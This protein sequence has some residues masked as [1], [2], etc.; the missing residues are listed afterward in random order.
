[1]TRQSLVPIAILATSI[2]ALAAPQSATTASKQSENYP[3][4]LARQ[5]VGA[6]VF[7]FNS[8]TQSYTTTEAAAA[9][10]DDDATT[11]WPIMAGK[12]HYLLALPEPDVMS[13]FAVSTRST[14]GT[15]TLFAGDEPA[16]PGAK[17][18]SPVARNVE[19]ESINGRKLGKPFSRFA[20]YL[21]I[22]TDIADPGPLFSLYLYGERAASSYV[23]AKREKS[24][25]TKSI[26]GYVN[27][28]TAISHSS[29]YLG[30]RVTFAAG[31]ST[32]AAQKAIDDNPESGVSIA[33]STDS[34]G[35]VMKFNG[36]PSISRLAVLTGTALKGQLDFFLTDTAPAEGQAAS[37]A[38]LKPTISMAFD[39]STTRQAMDFPATAA[40]ALL[41]RWNPETG[42][43]PL[44]IREINAFNGLS[45]S[46]YALGMTPEA[47]AELVKNG[48]VSKD[49]KS[50]KDGKSLPEV[51]EF[52]P[53]RSPYLPGAL[54]FPPN[55][56]GRIPP[57][58]PPDSSP[59]N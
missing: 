48:D 13:N 43:D 27:D 36:T 2:A 19:L 45:L 11:G 59:S 26:F 6:N 25:D 9:W 57:P 7:I 15:I 20:K 5:H 58:L 38:G 42:T 52:R 40:G 10:L 33:P 18:W 29:L 35:L 12:Q 56:T 8:A 16:A 47:V 49:G 23:L 37:L 1:M 39:G 14:A 51:G 4:N 46:E 31:A 24:I 30:S 50:F 22:E 34:A 21:L 28:Q 3:K 55:L 53:S 17:T 32:S 41:V 54:G 44:A